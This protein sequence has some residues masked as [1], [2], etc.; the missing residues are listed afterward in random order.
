MLMAKFFVIAG[1]AFICWSCFMFYMVYEQHK[2]QVYACS[3][4]KPNT[5]V[6]VVKLCER[7]TKKGSK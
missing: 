6:D 2:S 7:L 1:A 5:P 3:D 4:L